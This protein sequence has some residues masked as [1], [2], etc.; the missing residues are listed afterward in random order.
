[1]G[2]GRAAAL[3]YAREGA[4]V[5]VADRDEV[6]ARETAEMIEGEGG[7]ATSVGVDV[8]N[9]LDI[10]DM[11][12]AC[13][14]KWGRLDI[15]HN[16][17]GVSKAGGDAPVTEITPEAFTHIMDVNL[18]GMVLACKHALPVMRA[19]GSGAIIN[20][21][22]VAA[23]ID[24]PLVTYKTSKAGVVSLT[25]HLAITNAKFGVRA[26]V[27]LPGLI[28]TPMAVESQ[29]LELGLTRN[30][31]LA[32][33]SA[34]TPLRA[35]PGNAWD[36]AHAALFLASDEAAFITGTALTVDGGQSL[37]VG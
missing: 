11:V 36:V 13:I 6:S 12:A 15:L 24:Y 34:R 29:A 18:R 32:R 4:K 28:D 20:I 37:I 5:L 17:V 31:V 10:E 21:S 3:L 7:A 16:N 23:T 30:E 35:R 19:Q 2:N 26:N 8:K 22:S 14:K 9:E 1:V 25:E 33:R 27:V